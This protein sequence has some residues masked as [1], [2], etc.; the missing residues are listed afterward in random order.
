MKHLLLSAVSFLNHH[1][2]VKPVTEVKTVLAAKPALDTHLFAIAMRNLT[3]GDGSEDK[4]I[5]I[6]PMQQR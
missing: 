2:A 5:C 6:Y 3:P 1:H 4:T